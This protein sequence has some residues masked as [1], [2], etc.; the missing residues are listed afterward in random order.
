MTELD[1]MW[2]EDTDDP[3]GTVKLHVAFTDQ[4]DYVHYGMVGAAGDRVAVARM[5][6][7]LALRI[8]Q[9]APAGLH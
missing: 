6:R 5:L 8:E 4:P 1:Y 9:N 2:V 7:N 3:D